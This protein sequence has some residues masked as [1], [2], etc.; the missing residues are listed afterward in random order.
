MR[1]RKFFHPSRELVTHSGNGTY[2][3]IDTDDVRGVCLIKEY[4][5]DNE[6]L[7]DIFEWCNDQD[8]RIW[9]ISDLVYFD[10]KEIEINFF[11]RWAGILTKA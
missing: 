6:L 4:D 5:A 9:A 3:F 7:E 8:E 10:N 11:L 1:Y 2:E